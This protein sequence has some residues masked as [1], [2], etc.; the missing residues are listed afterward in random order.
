MGDR[1]RRGLP[2]RRPSVAGMDALTQMYADAWSR[3]PAEVLELVV[4]PTPRRPEDDAG[5][6]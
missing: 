4:V 5:D 1:P 2:E 6:N 3:L